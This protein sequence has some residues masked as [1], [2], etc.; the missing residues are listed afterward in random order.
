MSRSKALCL[1]IVLVFGIF[2]GISCSGDTILDS[3][4]PT[5]AT[6]PPAVQVKTPIDVG[7]SNSGII[8]TPAHL[9]LP[10]KRQVPPTDIQSQVRWFD[11]GA[12]GRG[13]WGCCRITNDSKLQVFGYWS[14]FSAVRG[15]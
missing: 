10:V 14:Y 3:Q 13:P 15:E 2:W 8:S 1:C 7:V 4:L 9:I 11:S 5:L 6:Q 12:G